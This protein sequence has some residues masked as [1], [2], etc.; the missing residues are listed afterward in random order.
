LNCT[1]SLVLP[2][3]FI[4][5]FSGTSYVLGPSI[6]PHLNFPPFSHSLCLGDVVMSLRRL[7]CSLLFAG[8]S[9]RPHTNKKSFCTYAE[10]L[11]CVLSF[12]GPSMQCRFYALLFVPPQFRGEAFFFMSGATNQTPIPAAALFS[13]LWRLLHPP[14]PGLLFF[15]FSAERVPPW[16]LSSL[17]NIERILLFSLGVQD[18]YSCDW[19]FCLVFNDRT[20][21]FHAVSSFYFFL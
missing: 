6:S 18:S 14:C 3:P 1:P 19:R 13:R 16:T 17:R 2:R 12:N 8:I 7:F 20:T 10:V 15:L 4:F 9:R 11:R 5:F 21:F